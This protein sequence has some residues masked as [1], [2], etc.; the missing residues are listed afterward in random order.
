MLGVILALA[1]IL[2]L[3]IR[4]P[5]GQGIIVDKATNYVSNKT[6]TEVSIKRLFITFSGNIYLEDLY[7]EDIDGDTLL[8]SKN[9]EAGVAFAPLLT[10]GNINVTKRLGRC[11]L[12]SK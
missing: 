11:G 2:I 12:Q 7:L 4:S 8:Y 5:W 9:L 1:F 6:G 3:F 10:T